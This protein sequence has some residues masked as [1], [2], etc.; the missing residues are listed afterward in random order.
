[1][2]EYQECNNINE[3]NKTEIPISKKILEK[4]TFKKRMGSLLL[5]I[6][7]IMCSKQKVKNRRQKKLV[8]SL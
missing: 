8:L 2:K 3:E 7:F 5:R 1:M 4:L 6:R